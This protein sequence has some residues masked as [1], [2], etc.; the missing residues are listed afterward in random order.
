M[1]KL[2]RSNRSGPLD[3]LPFPFSFPF[4]SP[5]PWSKH[6]LKVLGILLWNRMP[7]IYE[8][9][10]GVW[11]TNHLFHRVQLIILKLNQLISRISSSPSCLGLEYSGIWCTS[12][13]LVYISQLFDFFLI[14]SRNASSFF[15]NRHRPS[16]SDFY[17]F[18][19]FLWQL[20]DGKEGRPSIPDD[21]R[22]D[23]QAYHLTL[24]ISRMVQRL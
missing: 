24:G 19:T 15:S 5:N 23:W 9:C 3:H 22:S 4:S 16:C 6:S 8:F 18:D 7:K 10:S 12:L 11:A 17:T 2:R 20:F 21:C 13:F 14:C 1:E